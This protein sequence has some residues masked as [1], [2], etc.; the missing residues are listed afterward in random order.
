MVNTD[1]DFAKFPNDI[2]EELSRTRLS[3]LQLRT[4]LYIFRWTVGYRNM[5]RRLLS[6]ARMAK[7]MGYN[8]SGFSRQHVQDAV[9]DLQQMGMIKLMP[10]GR[11]AKAEFE[12]LPPEYWDKHAPPDGQV[13]EK[14]QGQVT[15]PSRRASHAPPDGQEHAPISGQHQRYKDNCID[16]VVKTRESA[17][18][19]SD[20]DDDGEDPLVLWERIKYKYGK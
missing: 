11:G 1:K 10:R 3:S 13:D 8:G 15:C 2:L 18:Q 17:G 6:T 12:I 14:K 4:F 16:K 19:E 5:Q 9:R 20:D 7:D